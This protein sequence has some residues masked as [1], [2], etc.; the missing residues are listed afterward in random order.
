YAPKINTMTSTLRHCSSYHEDFE[1]SLRLEKSHNYS[2]LD[3]SDENCS[4]NCSGPSSLPT[5]STSGR[6]SAPA[7]RH[8]TPTS[9]R[10]NRLLGVPRLSTESLAGSVTSTRSDASYQSSRE[11]HRSRSRSPRPQTESDAIETPGI[12]QEAFTRALIYPSTLHH[13]LRLLA[14]FIVM[15]HVSHKTIGPWLVYPI[16][17]KLSFDWS[18]RS[19][20]VSFP[21]SP[22]RW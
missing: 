20:T 7:S 16:L 14:I 15:A 19:L 10:R 5:N 17:K 8:T 2:S 6:K 1:K 4:K 18:P 11:R 13:N 9:V 21:W 12:Q 22:F 3:L